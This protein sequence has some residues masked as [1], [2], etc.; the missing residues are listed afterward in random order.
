MQKNLIIL[1]AVV[2]M[3]IC[4]ALNMQ[5]DAIDADQARVIASEFRSNRH[6]GKRLNNGAATDLTL[7][8]TRFSSSQQDKPVYYVFAD[9]NHGGWV[10]VSAD[11][12]AVQVLGYSESGSFDTDAMPCNMRSWL[13]GY[14]SQIEYLQAHPAIKG[15]AEAPRHD[16]PLSEIAP[17]LTTAWDQEQPYNGQ[18]PKVGNYPTFTGCVATAMA[19]VMYYHRYPLAECLG[20]PAYTSKKGINLPALPSVVFDWDKMLPRYY[21]YTADQAYAVA[22]LMRYCGQSVEMDYGT[23]VS[24]ATF[25]VIPFAMNYYFG[26]SN[27][28]MTYMRD[29]SNDADWDQM[30]YDELAAGRPVIYMGSDGNSAGHAF[31]L[32]GY[33]NT[34]FHINWG[35]GGSNDTYWQL[36]A[37]TP[38]G[39]NY[40]TRQYAILG[41]D[42]DYADVNGDNAI[43]ISDLSNLIDLLLAGSPSGRIGDVNNDGM[44]DIADVSSMV[45]LLL[46]GAGQEDTGGEAFTVGDVTFR[47]V[48][49]DGG[50]F[51]M[52]ATDEQADGAYSNEFPVHHVTL[53]SY[54]IGK[55]EVT[56]GLWKAVMGTNPSSVRG[57]ELPVSNVSWND[58]M[59]FITKLNAMTGK[60]FRLPT[61]AEWEFAAR[62][63]NKSQGYIYAGSDDID[64]VAWYFD[65]ACYSYGRRVAQKLPNELGIYDMCGNNYE[66]CA[67]FYGDYPAEAQTNPQGPATG[68]DKV[69]RSGSWYTPA[70]QCRNSSRVYGALN[71][72]GVHLG[73]RLAL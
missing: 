20:I 22:Q 73:L 23:Q 29:T 58:C 66:W 10:M 5:A 32:D 59:T 52:G 70:D 43:D 50:S 30:M 72:T 6:D 65:N 8:H 64:A 49:V 17:M 34:M 35:W 31:V 42:R 25:Q 14:S 39:N 7:S 26:Y 48:K 53:S 18:C 37:L 67:D 55:T 62:G 1:S 36:S 63:G 46:S 11:D 71:E 15:A 61:E 13:D 2:V 57:V 40:S 21:S 60:S 44:T 41:L 9:E 3:A 16:A 12:R 27:S 33:R 19:Q 47:M 69:I 51:D 45:D 56:Q 54:Y 38:N 68:T 28:A 24:N 4:G